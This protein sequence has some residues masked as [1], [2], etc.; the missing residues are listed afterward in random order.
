MEAAVRHS[1]MSM[2]SSEE[3]ADRVWMI[4]RTERARGSGL[5]CDVCGRKSGRNTVCFLPHQRISF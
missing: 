3:E 1:K 2:S 4:K 5:L